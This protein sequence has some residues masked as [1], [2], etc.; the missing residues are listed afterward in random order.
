M[1]NLKKIALRKSQISKRFAELAE[2][3][4]QTPETRAV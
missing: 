3:E 4:E 2:L 1:T